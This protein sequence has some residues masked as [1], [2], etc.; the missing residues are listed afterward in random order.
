MS[1]ATYEIKDIEGNLHIYPNMEDCYCDNG[2]YYPLNENGERLP[3][4]CPRCGGKHKQ[5]IKAT[6]CSHVPAGFLQWMYDGENIKIVFR[7][8]KGRGDDRWYSNDLFSVGDYGRWKDSPNHQDKIRKE[9]LE[10]H[11]LQF[12]K[13]VRDSDNRLCDN[14]EV[15][16]HDAGYSVYATW[17]KEESMFTEKLENLKKEGEA[18]AK[19]HGHKLHGW[20]NQSNGSSTNLCYM[21]KKEVIIKTQPRSNEIGIGGEA[22]ALGCGTYVKFNNGSFG[23]GNYFVG[24]RVKTQWGWRTVVEK[25][26]KYSKSAMGEMPNGC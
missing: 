4:P 21:C 23:Y 1:N 5:A 2:K 11:F 19:H 6:L 18:A 15:A 7:Y 9:I 12:C 25:I 26:Y 17:S 10:D 20:V 24:E 22:V 3:Q 8:D 14:I 16:M 13:I